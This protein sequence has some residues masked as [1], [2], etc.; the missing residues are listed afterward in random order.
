METSKQ[1]QKYALWGAGA[2]GAI[3]IAVT[4]SMLLTPDEPIKI[5]KPI[6][7]KITPAVVEVIPPEVIEPMVELEPVEE[8]IEVVTAPVKKIEPLP[9]L[10]NSDSWIQKKIAS[11]TWRKELLNLMVNE[12]M[13]RRF[14]VFTDNF[15][16]GV[17]AYE[18]SPFILPGT[19]FSVIESKD[20]IEQAINGG[21][22]VNNQPAI[23]LHW[24][25]ASAR[26]F[27]LYVDLLRS[28][29]STVLVNWYS[30]AKPLIDQAYSELGYPND[31]FTETLQIAITRVLDME[32]PEDN[33]DLVQPSV[34]YR[35]KNKELESLEA[36]DKLLLRLGKDNLLIIKSILL[37][38]NNKLNNQ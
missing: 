38:I 32:F 24:D 1:T 4:A 11:F 16:Q 10:N 36:T 31:D 33:F 7:K 23:A 17:L 37:E 12:D 20:V 21:N 29:D 25:E 15:S 8:I 30:D 13:V 9:T 35:F 26:R 28:M 5:E 22:V 27:S 2:V 3:I 18:H 6:I 14:V 19:K 34:M